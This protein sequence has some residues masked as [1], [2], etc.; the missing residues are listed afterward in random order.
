MVIGFAVIGALLV[1][2][3][4]RGPPRNGHE[5]IPNINATQAAIMKER[6]FDG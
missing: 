6:Y 5:L 4:P 3:I 1:M 2:L